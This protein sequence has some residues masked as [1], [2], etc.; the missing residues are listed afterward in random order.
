[1]PTAS[2]ARAGIELFSKAFGHSPA[3]EAIFDREAVYEKVYT[4]VVDMS[5]VKRGALIT[6]EKKDNLSG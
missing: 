6:F 3:P 4:A 1:L 2:K 5:R